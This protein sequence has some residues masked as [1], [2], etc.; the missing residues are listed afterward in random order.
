MSISLFSAHETNLRAKPRLVRQRRMNLDLLGIDLV[1][2]HQ[3]AGDRLRPLLGESLGLIFRAMSIAENVQIF[4]G[5]ILD[6]LGD[7]R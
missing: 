5:V 2:V 3:D 7:L 6:G 4:Q 1:L